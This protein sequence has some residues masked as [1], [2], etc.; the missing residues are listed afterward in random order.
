L[1]GE[2]VDYCRVFG[3]CSLLAELCRL[4]VAGSCGPNLP[5]RDPLPMQAC[6]EIAGEHT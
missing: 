1:F 2:H 4:R 3:P 6:D 5:G